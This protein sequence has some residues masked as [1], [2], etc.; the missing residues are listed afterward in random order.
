MSGTNY[1][2]SIIE[3]FD[4]I[5]LRNTPILCIILID[6]NNPIVVAIYPDP[7]VNDVICKTVLA[8]TLGVKAI[9]GMWRDQL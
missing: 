1:R 3:H 4:E 2:G 9:P 7:M 8:V 6:P 5:V